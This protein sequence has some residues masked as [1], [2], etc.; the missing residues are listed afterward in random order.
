VFP[1]KVPLEATGKLSK[2]KIAASGIC[3]LER[4]VM[5]ILYN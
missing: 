1:G 5:Q 4:L 3:Q 2:V